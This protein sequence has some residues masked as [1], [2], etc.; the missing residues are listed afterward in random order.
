MSEKITG[1]IDHVVFEMKKTATQ[2]WYLKPQIP[3]KKSPAWEPFR[4]LPRG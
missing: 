4:I 2:L 1:Y 3:R